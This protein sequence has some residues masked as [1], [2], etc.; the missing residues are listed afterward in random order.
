MPMAV[1]LA[2]G[3]RRAAPK[4]Q[5]PVLGGGVEV[6]TAPL[7]TIGGAERRSVRPSAADRLPLES[8]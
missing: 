2:A 3:T 7:K 8:P 1:P 6:R 5:R 4:R